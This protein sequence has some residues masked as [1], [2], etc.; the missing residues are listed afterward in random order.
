MKERAVQW[1]TYTVRPHIIE[2]IG[3]YKIT[4][5]KKSMKHRQKK[6][7]LTFFLTT[8]IILGMIAVPE[9]PL[10]M[11]TEIEATSFVS[12]C[13]GSPRCTNT[14]WHQIE[15]G[16][17]VM[18]GSG[19][20][21]G[22]LTGWHQLSW[23][24]T[25]HW[26]YFRS[27][28]TADWTE[29]NGPVGSMVEGWGEVRNSKS[30]NSTTRSWFYF[31]RASNQEVT[32]TMRTGSF[33]DT[34]EQQ[35]FLDNTTTNINNRGRMITGWHM[36]NNVGETRYYRTGTNNPNTGSW[37]SM[38]RSNSSTTTVSVPITHNGVMVA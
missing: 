2:A 34:D 12:Q 3:I 17:W 29:N 13:T 14:G 30:N 6:R 15:S 5:R 24:N 23:G 38:I 11:M 22:H 7:I 1:A 35:Y 19:T 16:F 9:S 31:H 32:G 20:G 36:D 37:G 10:S 8:A 33:I 26:Y 21:N 27:D 4:R 25:T 28:I 18:G